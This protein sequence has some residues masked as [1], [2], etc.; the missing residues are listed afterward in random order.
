MDR[1]TEYICGA[2]HGKRGRTIEEAGKSKD[3]C[4]GEFEAT[5]C[6]DKLAQYEDTGL[7]PDE[8]KDHE[9]MFKAYRHVCGGLAPD[10]I[11][12]WIPCSKRMP[13]EACGCLLIVEEDDFFGEPQE[14]LLPYFAG[15]DGE[16]WN[17]GDGQHVPFEVIYWQPLPQPPKEEK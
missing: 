16:Q 15:Y 10:E 14:V 11:P 6:I 4:R 1:L 5:G 12:Q 17:D 7:E 2:A 3:F 8:I 9:E 13:E